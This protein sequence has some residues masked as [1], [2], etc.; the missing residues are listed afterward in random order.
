MNL[1]ILLKQRKTVFVNKLFKFYKMPVVNIFCNILIN[2]K[3]LLVK[4]EQ[5]RLSFQA[6]HIKYCKA[7]K[8]AI[9]MMLKKIIERVQFFQVQLPKSVITILHNS[10]IKHIQCIFYRVCYKSCSR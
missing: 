2:F 5:M 3:K 10:N 4:N 1:I 8:K 9:F 7:E 6:R